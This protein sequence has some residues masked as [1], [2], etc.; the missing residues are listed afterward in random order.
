M[1]QFHKAEF[2]PVN[3]NKYIGKTPI[4][5]RS[6]WELSM[7]RVLDA[8]P[9]VLQWSSESISIPY[10]N[11]LT[12]RWSMYIPDFMIIYMDKTNKKHC[13]IVEI[14]PAKEVPG[15]TKK[16]LDERAKL[17]QAINAAKWSAAL[18]FCL[19]RGW[20]FRVATER[21]LYGYKV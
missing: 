15:Y 4:I 7:M 16:R 10:R 18:E 8:H 13:E 11:P 14:K 21:E 5:F 9:S 6:S 2:K 20:K 17:A 1:G 19:K 12:G 3:E